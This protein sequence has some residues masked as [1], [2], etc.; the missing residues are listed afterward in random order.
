MD[1]LHRRLDGLTTDVVINDFVVIVR[2]EDPVKDELFI[3]ICAD[4]FVLQ[5]G[6]LVYL[7]ENG[8][9]LFSSE[10]LS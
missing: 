4:D 3:R 7:P 5:N 6:I 1:S 2:G 9:T 10:W 8:R